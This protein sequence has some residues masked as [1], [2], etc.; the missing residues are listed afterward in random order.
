VHTPPAPRTDQAA[1]PAPARLGR[2]EI[3]RK[4][5]AGGMAELHLA[6]VTGIEGFEKLVVIKRILPQLA[7][8]ADFV[9]MFLDE[10]RIA[11]TL[12]H[13]NIVQVYDMGVIDGSYFCAMEFL[14]G[15]D[16]RQV[17]KASRAQEREVP[18]EHT[19]SI[20]IG[21]CAGLNYAHEKAAPDGGPLGIVHRDVSPQNVF[22]T[23]EGGV[24]LLDFGIAKASHR[25]TSTRHG[26][27]KGK[28]PYMSPEQCRGEPL[29]RRSDVYAVAVMLWELTTGCRLR[30]QGS[31]FEIMKAIVEEEAPRPSSVKPGYPPDLEVI[32][33]RGLMRDQRQ[34]HQTAQELQLDLEAFAREWKLAVSSVSLAHFMKTLFQADLEAWNA[35]QREGAAL[36]DHIAHTF[37]GR[38]STPAIDAAPGDTGSDLAGVVPEALEVA[39]TV[40]AAPSHHGAPETATGLPSRGWVKRPGGAA[41]VEDQAPARDAI[42]AASMPRVKPRRRGLVLVAVVAGVLAASAVWLALDARRPGPDAHPATPAPVAAPDAAILP[43]AA[44][45]AAPATRPASPIAPVPAARRGATPVTK[46]APVHLTAKAAAPGKHGVRSR[47][48]RRKAPGRD[49]APRKP[50]PIEDLNAPLP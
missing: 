7:N 12:H 48:P 50:A 44:A 25:L 5:A 36:A 29:D 4:L 16:V 26:T 10:A 2:Y 33:M 40:P 47:P 35:A 37:Q 28:I 18:L 46:T 19:L 41:A 45:A 42:P 9:Q 31:E 17:F 43:G 3:L 21:A 38:G 23:F 22:V 1:A 11:A 14:H 27:L 24:K 30:R 34:R 6:R 13:S 8:Q 20:L 32:V 39:P 15:A 49:G